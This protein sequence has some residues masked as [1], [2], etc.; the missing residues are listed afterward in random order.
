MLTLNNRLSVCADL[1][2]KGGT[3]VDVGTDHAYLAT[4]LVLN[5]ISKN[6]I[7][8]DINE[9]PL[10]TARQTLERYN[11]SDRIK[12]LK[13]DGLKNVPDENVTDVIIAGMGGEL[14]SSIIENAQWL[15]RGTNIIAQPMTKAEALRK[16]LYENGYK[17]LSEKA[18]T[19]ENFTYSVMQIVYSGEK[20]IVSELFSYTGLID[21]NDLEGKKYL[22]LQAGRLNKIS[23]GLENSDGKKKQAQKY[24]ELYES[25]LKRIGELL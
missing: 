7:A 19:D 21:E 9:K 17:I 22:M 5:N 10:N 3:A 13:S 15:K 16:W 6:V 24:K 2:T 23:K 4:Y 11:V 18:V 14:I 20:V 1:V 12:L 25:I 8:C